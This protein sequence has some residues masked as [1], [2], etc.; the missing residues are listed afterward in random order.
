[1]A[2]RVQVPQG[3]ITQIAFGKTGGTLPVTLRTGRDESLN[4]GPLAPTTTFTGG[5]SSLMVAVVC[6][7]RWRKC[8]S[9]RCRSAKC[10][11]ALKADANSTYVKVCV[12][13]IRWAGDC[14]AVVSLTGVDD[15]SNSGLPDQFLAFLDSAQAEAYQQ[16]LYPAA[17][18][19]GFSD[20]HLCDVRVHGLSFPF[21]E[22]VMR[23]CPL[24][25]AEGNQDLG[26]TE[27]KLLSDVMD[28]RESR[29]PCSVGEALA[30]S[31]QLRVPALVCVAYLLRT[32]K[33][34]LDKALLKGAFCKEQD[35]QQECA[36][37]MYELSD[38]LKRWTVEADQ[39]TADAAE[40]GQLL[41]DLNAFAWC[42]LFSQSSLSEELCDW[43]SGFRQYQQLHSQFPF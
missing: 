32:A 36:L 6:A 41:R 31:E 15:Y 30:A 10:K 14:G 28:L 42:W 22:L 13:Q 7:S 1:M 4:A 38:K 37:E 19:A 27:P 8:A 21:G 39:G 16:V 5:M 2:L 33:T 9:N 20:D 26:D 25:L 17:F 12:G 40:G 3:H 34:C 43:E 29:L 18:G 24:D 11:H 23:P 35:D